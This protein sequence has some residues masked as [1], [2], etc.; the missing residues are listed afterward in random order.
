[1]RTYKHLMMV[2]FLVMAISL[3]V[4]ILLENNNSSNCSLVINIFVGIFSSSLLLFINSVVGFLVEKS[5]FLKELKVKVNAMRLYVKK[6]TCSYTT[7]NTEGL[8]ICNITLDEN[9]KR[10]LFEI[11][12][13]A[14]E[15][16][17]SLKGLPKWM[18]VKEIDVEALDEFCKDITTLAELICEMEVDKTIKVDIK[19]IKSIFDLEKINNII[20]L[21]SDKNK[22]EYISWTV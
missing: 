9:F 7:K 22:N 5:K 3:M 15:V 20:K 17:E 1:M 4:T 2:T 11:A 14:F 16:S 13:Y 21:Y 19:R 6:T 10:A 8:N 18:S 12:P